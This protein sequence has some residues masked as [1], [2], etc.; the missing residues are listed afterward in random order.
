MRYAAYVRVSHEEQ[1]TGYSLDAQRR[2]IREWVAGKGGTLV[3]IYADEGESALTAARTSFQKMRLDARH[4]KFDALIVHKFDRFARNRT[5]SLAIK[6]LLRYDYGI[7]VFSVSEPS[8]DSDGPIGALIEGIMEC[9][10]DWYSRNLASEVAKGKRERAQQGIHNNQACF[11]YNKN[12]DKQLV[13]NTDEEQGVLLAY[14]TYSDGKHS[15]NDIANLLNEAGYKTKK[16]RPFSLET[17]RDMLQN[18]TYLGRVKYQAFRRN[19]DRTRSYSAPEQWFDGKHPA[20]ISQELFDLCQQVRAGRAVH[21]QPTPKYNSYLLRD[22][23]YCYRCCANAPTEYSFPSY[24]K[25]RAH[26]QTKK[27]GEYRYYRCRARDFN[28]HCEQKG[29]LCDLIEYQVIQTLMQ[30]KPPLEWRKNITT[31]MSEILGEQNLE[32]RL[33]QIKEAI[34]RMDFR[35][36]QGFIT[37]KMD[38]LE[39]RVKLQQ[40]LEQLTP[41]PEDDL[42]RAADML[43][44]FEKHWKACEGDPEAEY[45]LIKL[46]V[47]K[48]Y[49]QD[50]QVVAITMKADYHVVLGHNENGSIEMSIDPG[51]Y[52]FGSDGIR[53]RDL[54]LDR[55]IC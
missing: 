50:E 10:A 3:K 11:G 55:A 1:V 18:Q 31:A 40:E 15:D 54:C 45:K 33:T 13:V 38:Y 12:Q 51:V 39:K 37:D 5:D 17:V 42:T 30:L 16:G 47:D 23:I 24:G 46:I 7:K 44:N 21:R 2:A 34:D 41:I 53:T 28:R 6:S 22:L 49:V 19:A 8:E 26:C 35:W 27:Y 25:M 14:N 29:V 48:V 52:T 9:V 20:I 32:D 36:D 4:G 43:E